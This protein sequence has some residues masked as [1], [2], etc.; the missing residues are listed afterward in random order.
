MFFF[1]LATRVSFFTF[2]SR[3]L[4]FVRD[5]LIASILGVGFYADVFFV[6]FRFPNTFRRLLAEGSFNSSFI[7]I[8]SNEIEKSGKKNALIFAENILSIFFIC[9]IFLVAIFIFFMPWLIYLIAPGFIE[10]ANKIDTAIY[11][12]RLTFPYLFFIIISSV[13]VGILNSFNKFSFA[14]AQPIILN[15]VLVAI[16]IVAHQKNIMTAAWLSTGVSLAGFLQLVS[17]VIYTGF[18]GINIKP[19]KPAITK[20][21]K[22]FF[23][24][25]IPSSLS[26]GVLQINILIGT[27]IASFQNG[28]VSFLYY[29]DRIYQLPLALIGISI[30]TV[31]LPHLSKFVSQKDDLGT[32]NIQNRSCELV[33]LFTIPATVA[34]IVI[35]TEILTVLFQRGSFDLFATTQTAKALIAFAT[36]LPAYSLI[37]VLSP[38]FF[39]RHNTVIPF[40]F[41]LVS[42]VINIILSLVLFQ[43]FGHV[44]IAISTSIAAWVN[45]ALLVFKLYKLKYLNFD[46][47]IKSSFIKIF[48]ISI[49]MGFILALASKM[50]NFFSYELLFE[51]ILAL[52]SIIFMGMIFYFCACIIVKVL[53]FSEIKNFSAK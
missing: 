52:S 22:K 7:P 2:L 35:P 4:G 1:R 5:I 40:K 46:K 27:V 8:I 3:I 49:F 6:A 32:Q 39:A 50:I 12:S 41:A 15:V 24:L 53:N 17:L 9:L 29:A 51:K 25:L 48:V 13:Y 28:A 34:L 38:M 14:A 36:G 21:V 19:F 42:V 33:L 11:F 18:L 45:L 23:N 16:L 47:K 10:D 44:G 43:Y 37:K 30:A 20:K 26:A 31:L